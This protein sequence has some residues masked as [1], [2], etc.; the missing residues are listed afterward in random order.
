MSEEPNAAKSFVSR[1]LDPCYMNRLFRRSRIT[2]AECSK[3]LGVSRST[4]QEWIDP[5]S[6]TQWPY[7]AQFALERLTERKDK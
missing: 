4:L 6:D 1:E 3:R 5:E 7:A 2:Q